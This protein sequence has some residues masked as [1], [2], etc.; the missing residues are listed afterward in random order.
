M[1]FCFEC[2]FENVTLYTGLIGYLIIYTVLF[3]RI[4][5]KQHFKQRIISM[6]LLTAIF[7]C[8]E[9][10]QFPL[11]QSHN[12]RML[13]YNIELFRFVR[14]IQVYESTRVLKLSLLNVLL[15]VPV[16]SLM[17]LSRGSKRLLVT[18]TSGFLLSFLLE[19]MQLVSG[20]VMGT[21][22][23]FDVDDLLL[24]TIGTLLGCLLVR[25]VKF[26]NPTNKTK[27]WIAISYFMG[28]GFIS[29]IIYVCSHIIY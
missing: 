11:R 7:I 13:N 24:N 8:V 22:R 6:L 26:D 19:L 28:I 10:T 15:F 5:R 18:I 3:F 20:Y 21:Y 29:S 2:N 14:E 16:G 23:I 9:M 1:D 25:F 12:T 17:F 4:Y 27:R